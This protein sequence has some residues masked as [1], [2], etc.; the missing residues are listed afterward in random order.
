MAVHHCRLQPSQFTASTAFISTLFKASAYNY[1]IIVP[2]QAYRREQSYGVCICLHRSRSRRFRFLVLPPRLRPLNSHPPTLGQSQYPNILANSS[3]A[4]SSVSSYPIHWRTP[5]KMA[6]S[7]FASLSGTLNLALS[8]FFSRTPFF[9]T[10]L[11]SH[12]LERQCHSHTSHAYHPI[13][14]HR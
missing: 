13:V 2:R 4:N 11:R 5:P 8:Q 7:A 10:V 1:E 6:N 14:P 3:L 9:P 12:P